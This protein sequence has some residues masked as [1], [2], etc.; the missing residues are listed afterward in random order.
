MGDCAR[1]NRYPLKSAQFFFV[2]WRGVNRVPLYHCLSGWGKTGA[3]TCIG[4]QVTPRDPVWQVTLRIV[5]RW[6]STNSLRLYR[7]KG[8][9]VEKIVASI[10]G[11]KMLQPAESYLR[12]SS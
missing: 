4:W 10:F 2:L 12:L 1:V 6:F 8:V 5:L 9:R 3:F 11:L 7:C